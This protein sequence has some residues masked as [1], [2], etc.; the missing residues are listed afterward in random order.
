MMNVIIFGAGYH[1]R[2]ALRKCYEDKKINCI[3]FVDNN[4]K[5][6]GKKILGKKIYKPDIINRTNFDKLILCGRYIDEQLK[7]LS[8][9]K[10]NNKILIWGRKKIQ[11]HKRKLQEREQKLL[12]ILKYII[13]KFEKKNINYWIDYSG[14]LSLKRKEN[15]ATLSD[16]D[17][18]VDINDLKKILSLLNIH[19]KLFKLYYS[20]NSQNIQKKKSIKLYLL[21]KTNLN[22]LEPPAIDFVFQIF[23]KNNSVNVNT[24]KSYLI[25]YW[26]SYEII[27]YKKINFRIP[28]FS[29]KYLKEVYG[30][31]WKKRPDK[32]SVSKKN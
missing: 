10:I 30:S 18:S 7:Q 24:K 1:G 6:S 19:N 8:E 27:K 28:C 21:G 23:N 22:Y 13:K 4:Q 15:L 17:I 31:L 29:E 2:A 32:W 12:S 3:F 25:K 16:V 14:L 20:S 5:L 9:Y 26:K 11:P